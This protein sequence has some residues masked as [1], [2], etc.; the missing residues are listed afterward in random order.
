MWT[1][2]HSVWSETVEDLKVYTKPWETMRLTMRLHDPRTDIM[3][4]T[5][6]P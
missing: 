3:V 6:H 2:T 1:T 5:A 4:T